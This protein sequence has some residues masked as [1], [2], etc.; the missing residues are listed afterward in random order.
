MTKQVQESVYNY[1][2]TS[3]RITSSLAELEE[4]LGAKKSIKILP[5]KVKSSV[6]FE[7][8]EKAENSIRINLQDGILKMISSRQSDDLSGL[9]NLVSLRKSQTKSQSKKKPR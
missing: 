9:S 1:N 4:K 8:P 2:V 6:M 7:E 5:P 3:R